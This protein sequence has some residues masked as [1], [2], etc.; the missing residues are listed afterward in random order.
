MRLPDSALRLISYYQRHGFWVAWRHAAVLFWR[1]VFQNG[2]VLLRCD[3]KMG[4]PQPVSSLPDGLTIERIQSSEQIHEQDWQKLTR[5]RTPA[6]C[7]R[8]FGERFRKGASMWA[9]RSNGDIAGYGWTQTCDRVETYYPADGND[10]YLFEFLVFPEHR[11]RRINS[12]LIGHILSALALEGK[13]RAYLDVDQWNKAGLN[14]YRR[15]SFLPVAISK[16]R[17]L[18]PRKLVKWISPNEVGW[19]DAELPAEKAAATDRKV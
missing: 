9:A 11:G 7:H 2:R 19:E 3:L 10:V 14:S 16:A 6:I 8:S 13:A 4:Q 12:L 1:A 15:T 18:R 17:L 5:D